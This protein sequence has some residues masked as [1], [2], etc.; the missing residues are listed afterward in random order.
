MQILS[1]W[2]ER[3]VRKHRNPCFQLRMVMPRS[4]AEGRG[5][6]VRM[7]ARTPLCAES[8]VRIAVIL[9]PRL[10]GECVPA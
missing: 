7:L 3:A 1:F 6:A 4:H 9:M 8:Q 2:N 10:G 5:I